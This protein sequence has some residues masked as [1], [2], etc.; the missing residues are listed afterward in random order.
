M[1]QQPATR[2]VN[3][4]YLNIRA[5]RTSTGDETQ[6]GVLPCRKRQGE[7]PVV[8]LSWPSR[9]HRVGL[10]HEN[11]F[12]CDSHHLKPI[13]PIPLC[14]FQT[15]DEDWRTHHL[16]SCFSFRSNH[17]CWYA[18]ST[19]SQLSGGSCV[20]L[21]LLARPTNTESHGLLKAHPGFV[22]STVD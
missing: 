12:D 20:L 10:R 19:G 21:A 13:Q 9:F 1:G 11:S 7:N 3:N 6:E 5:V 18:S 2:W 4:L 17:V 14:C 16:F 15:R 8:L 22:G